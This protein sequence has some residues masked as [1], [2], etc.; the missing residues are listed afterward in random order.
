MIWTW[1]DVETAITVFTI[2]LCTA[3]VLAGAALRLTPEPTPVE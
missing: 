1:Y 2:A 3:I